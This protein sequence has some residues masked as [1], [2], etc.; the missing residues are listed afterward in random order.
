MFVPYTIVNPL[1]IARIPR[2]LPRRG[3]VLAHVGQSVE[4]AHIVAQA[5]QPPDFR[6]IDIARELDLPIKKA[7]TCIK[8]KRGDKVSEGTPLAA[9][10]SLGGRVVRSPIAGV[11]AGLGRGRLL[12]EKR[13]RPIR[14]AALIPGT[15][16]AT[17]PEEGAIIETVGAYIQALWG[18]NREAYGTLRVVVRAPRHGIRA[19]HIDASSQGAILVGG[20]R[21]DAETLEQAVEMR[22]GGLILGG[23]SAELLPRI[24]ELPF[25]VMTTEG[26]GEMPM[27]QAIFDLLRSLNGR[28]AAL[29]AVLHHR[30]NIERP[31]IVVPMPTQAGNPVDPESP[32]TIGS[33]VRVLRGPFMGQS[34]AVTDVPMGRVELESGARFE[35]VFV[36]VG[37]ENIFVPYV[38]LERLL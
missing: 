16:V 3:E 21:I 6:I 20:S 27:S 18:N 30:G 28:D 7:K 37:K 10:G 1:T 26:I 12:L 23:I 32:L 5:K 11:I 29:S 25:P 38:N 22:V 17:L 34:G 13:S 14:V 4:P 8:V 24:K 19:K 2:R 33:R 15:V 35:G 9:R 31:Y 36:D